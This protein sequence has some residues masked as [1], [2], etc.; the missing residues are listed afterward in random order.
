MT[1]I[2]EVL[3]IGFDGTTDETDDRVIWVETDSLESVETLLDGVPHSRISEIFGEDEV[4]LVNPLA[5]VD[6]F[7]PEDADALKERLKRYEQ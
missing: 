4:N 6:Y 3:G 2:V 5:A 7:L 1:V